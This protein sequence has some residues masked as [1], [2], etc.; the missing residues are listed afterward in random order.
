MIPLL[1][2]VRKELGRPGFFSQEAAEEAEGSPCRAAPWPARR[3]VAP[4]APPP[5]RLRRD[6]LATAEASGEG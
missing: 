4:K 6:T 5:P 2:F 3:L 1:P